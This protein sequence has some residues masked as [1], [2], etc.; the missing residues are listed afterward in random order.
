MCDPSVSPSL[1][2]A[3]ARAGVQIVAWLL[4]KRL[5]SPQRRYAVLCAAQLGLAVAFASTL[6]GQLRAASTLPTYGA[7]TWLSGFMLVG[8]AAWSV[9]F[10]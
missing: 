9:R 10:L 3:L 4:T 8:V 5:R 1:T 2:H 7:A 6:I